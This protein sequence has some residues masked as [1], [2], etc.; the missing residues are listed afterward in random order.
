LFDRLGLAHALVPLK[1]ITVHVDFLRSLPK[2]VVRS[3]TLEEFSLGR[4]LLSTC[5]S[6]I[7]MHADV[8]SCYAFCTVSTSTVFPTY[9]V[10]Q[11]KVE[12]VQKYF[13]KPG[14]TG[15]TYSV[16]IPA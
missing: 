4:I 11:Q 16:G 2:D 14:K 5:I 12:K 6:C 3:P 13:L 8:C 1:C 9:L 10:R 7:L 15:F